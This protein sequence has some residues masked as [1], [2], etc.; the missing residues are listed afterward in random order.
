MLIKFD[1]ENKIARVCLK[2]ESILKEMY[3]REE[4]EKDKRISLWR[5]EFGA[6]MIE[7]TPG[8][9]YGA[10]NHDLELL[11]NF[12]TVEANM[13]ARREEIETLLDTDESLLC[14]TSYP[15]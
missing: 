4:E 10:T 3:K 15:R 11:S 5:P 1:H 12:N 6:F 9:P 14:I 7:G 13:K 8:S 2:A